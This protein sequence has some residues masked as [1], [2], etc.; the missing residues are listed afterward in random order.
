MTPQSTFVIDTD[1][2]YAAPMAQENLCR[3]KI[4]AVHQAT[5]V[6]LQYTFKK[7]QQ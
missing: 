6:Y 4:I 7:R 1:K 5:A 2:R 3:L